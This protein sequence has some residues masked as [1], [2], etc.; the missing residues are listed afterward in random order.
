MA[1]R[2]DGAEGRSPATN[3]PVG[4]NS[5]VIP[6]NYLQLGRQAR[7][8]LAYERETRPCAGA[9]VRRWSAGTWWS[10]SCER[11]PTR[12]R[13]VS[14]A[15]RSVLIRRRSL[16][17]RHV[18]AS[19]GAQSSSEISVIPSN[20][21]SPFV[22]DASPDALAGSDV[23]RC[24]RILAPCRPRPPCPPRSASPRSATLRLLLG[25]RHV[26]SRIYLSTKLSHGQIHVEILHII[27]NKH[28]T[29][30]NYGT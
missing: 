3:L 18:H 1:V 10:W 12:A 7:R 28:N 25:N 5:T 17:H 29:A 22:P 6:N 27:S 14:P 24:P 4:R 26:N 30:K 2:R 23:P 11:S 20:D 19:L 21:F 15:G 13:A 8:I 16:A 9:P